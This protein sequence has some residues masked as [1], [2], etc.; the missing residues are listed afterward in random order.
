M[1]GEL[2]YYQAHLSMLPCCRCGRSGSQV[3][4]P[5]QF[6]F[7]EPRGRDRRAH[8][9]FGLPLCPT[10]HGDLHRLSGRFKGWN[11]EKLHAWEKGHRERLW[12]AWSPPPDMDPF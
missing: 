9:S 6:R 1:A 3:H 12:G 11:R 8:D 4:H 2:P 5:T 7:S 10:C